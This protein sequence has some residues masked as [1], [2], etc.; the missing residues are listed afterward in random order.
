M[1]SPLRNQQSAAKRARGQWE[2]DEPVIIGDRYRLGRKVGSGSFG[3]IYL[4]T[5]IES[6]EKV[7]MKLEDVA[8][9]HPQLQYE[10]RLYQALADVQKQAGIPKVYMFCQM[11]SY[12][13]MVMELL[14]P[15]LED[16]FNFCSRKFTIKTV[17]LIA[18][19]LLTRIESIHRAGFIHRDIKPDNFL[20]GLGKRRLN[21]IFVI[22]FGLA[23]QYRHPKTRR[24]I[25]YREGKSLTGTARYA[26]IT[27]HLG[28]EQS[29]RD[30]L[31]SIGYVLLYFLRGSLPWQGLHARTK[32]EKYEKICEKKLGTTLESL[33][34]HLPAEFLTYVQYCRSLRFDEKP[35]Y[36]YLRRMFRNLFFKN[37]YHSDYRFDWIILNYG[38]KSQTDV[39]KLLADVQEGVANDKTDNLLIRRSSQG[40]LQHQ[41]K[42]SDPSSKQ[43]NVGWSEEENEGVNGFNGARPNASKPA[44]VSSGPR[45]PYSPV[46][47]GARYN[48]RRDSREAVAGGG[49]GIRN[50]F[51]APRRRDEIS[52]NVDRKLRDLELV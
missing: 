38:R 39:P 48:V 52:L 28:I 51:P 3:E 33:C 14:G 2:S 34:K 50:V 5:D 49:V 45:V 11:R 16:L 41:D 22:D 36:A 10:F 25:D 19:Q 35:D 15:S 13:V 46:Q 29:R 17:L 18:D 9:R 24:H 40:L 43:A 32:R 6:G 20:V 4:G 27:T 21:Q 8:L 26:S 44:P 47:R 37:M 1:G 12:H 31:E 30:D 42:P 23:K 7:A